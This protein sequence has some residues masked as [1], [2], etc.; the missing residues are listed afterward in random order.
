[1]EFAVDYERCQTANIPSGMMSWS[2]LADQQF[3]ID[4]ANETD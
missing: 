1:M 3:A 4:R 2:S